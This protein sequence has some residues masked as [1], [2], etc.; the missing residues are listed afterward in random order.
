MSEQILNTIQSLTT[1][2]IPAI[3]TIITFVCRSS[4]AI[5][6]FGNDMI[7]A[8]SGTLFYI[9]QKVYAKIEIVSVINCRCFFV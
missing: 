2:L 3:G 5:L 1:A 7:G 8:G 9:T 6:G 4:E